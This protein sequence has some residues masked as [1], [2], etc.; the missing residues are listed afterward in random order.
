MKA[1]R[2]SFIKSAGSLTVLFSLGH[3]GVFAAL[4]PG[5][6]PEL[7]GVLRSNP[8]LSAWIEVLAD[9]SVRVFTGKVELGQGLCGAIAQVVS[10]ELDLKVSQVE[11][12]IADT[13]RTPNEGFTGGSFST[14][15]S[16]ISVRYAAAAARR[17]LLDLA[18]EALGIAVDK[19]Q[20]LDGKVYQ[21]PGSRQISFFEL[22]DGRKLQS[23]VRL[24]IKLKPKGQ[25]RVSGHA[26]PREDFKKMIIG[27]EMYLQ[28]LRF[29]G[30]LHARTVSPPSYGARFLSYD[31]AEFLKT[32][33]VLKTI[34]DGSFIAVICEDE[35]QAVKAQSQLKDLVKWSVPQQSSPVQ[36]MPE[37]L[38][39]RTVESAKVKTA[40][41]AFPESAEVIKA[42]Y[43]K[44]YIMHC[45]IAPSCAV[46]R[47]DSG[48]L[49]VWT[50]SQGAY[51]LRDTISG[52]VDIPVKQIHVTCLRGAGCYGHN[53]ADDAAAEAAMIAVAFPGKHVRLQWSREQEHSWE[54]YGSAMYMELEG[55][56]GEGGRIEHFRNSIW[57]DTHY[58]R[59]NQGYLNATAYREEA[60]EQKKNP[61]G[62]GGF[63]N[64]DLYYSV[65]NQSV[66]ANFFD[67]PLRTSNLRSLGS[68]ANLFAV[69]SFMDELA[70]KAKID[71]FDFR[72]MHLKD[73]RALE[74]MQR[75]RRKVALL[76][77]PKNSGLGIAFSRYKNSAAYI[78]AAAEVS[79]DPM[80][81]K[82]T[83]R[84]LWAVVDVGEVISL[85]SVI[86]QVEGGII[87]AA[88]WTMFE[89]VKFEQQTVKSRNWASYP[90]IRFSDVP[91]VEVEVITRPDEKVEGVGEIAMCV[92][93]GA[94]TNAI[95]RACGKRIRNL[96]VN[97]G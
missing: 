42:S 21:T 28:D 33:K 77:M 89:E 81:F 67:G 53:G 45:A 84:K 8:A 94:I 79:I 34:I 56:L 80:N 32:G 39:S 48:I 35:Y 72:I 51:P 97:A 10:E 83:L 3:T 88:S 61:A 86:N 24:P 27:A 90:I 36:S 75:L 60:R 46:A 1:S 11:V 16:V 6:D 54:P 9:G 58:I 96:P 43:F 70:E 30:M 49:E 22:L 31:K 37:L 29:P 63:R 18:A 52:M 91:E 20:M 4:L 82:V 55:V 92:V 40:P 7:P 15:N 13:R 2:R 73:P 12:V 19:L 74:V 38:K 41:I 64:A 47:F 25:Y 5:Q 65:A 50:H 26:V 17:E 14:E 87:Q 68:F 57:S 23:E 95:A 85:D 66:T 78:A 62:S 69:E 59:G 44:P 93:P 71:P 76:T